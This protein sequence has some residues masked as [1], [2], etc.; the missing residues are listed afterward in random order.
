[1]RIAI[2]FSAMALTTGMALP[3]H[4]HSWYP[5]ECCSGED[6]AP[7]ERIDR[8]P[9]SGRWMITSRHGKAILRQ[10]LVP[11]ESQDDRAHVCMRFDEFG[12]AWIVCFF[13]P[14]TM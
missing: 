12:E 8:L 2:T 1:M 11:R 14:P 7:V 4:A 10:N 5:P 9:G 13:A 3:A 6:C